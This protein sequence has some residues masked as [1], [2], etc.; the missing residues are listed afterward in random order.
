MTPTEL[1]ELPPPLLQGTLGHEWSGV[2]WSEVRGGQGGKERGESN[3]YEGSV[4]VSRVQPGRLCVTILACL[5]SR[6]IEA[7]FFLLRRRGLFGRH[8]I[9]GSNRIRPVVTSPPVF[10]FMLI[11]GCAILCDPAAMLLVDCL[12]CLALGW[13][14][15]ADPRIIFAYYSLSTPGRRIIYDSADNQA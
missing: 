2:Q 13:T 15:V 3:E 7:F 9:S 4:S 14:G 10:W 12:E 1:P 11:A 8:D 5:C 6:R